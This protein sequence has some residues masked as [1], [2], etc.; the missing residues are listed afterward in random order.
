MV[1]GTHTDVGKTW[2]TAATAQA[3][4]SLGLAVA[5]RKP[6]ESFEASGGP[7]D[8]ELLAA[9]TAEDPALVCPRHRR[10][11][12]AMAPP[13][14]ADALGRPPFTIAELLGELRLPPRGIA[15]VETVGGPRSPIAADGDSV[16]LTGALQPDDVVLVGDAGLGAINALALSAAAL[17]PHPCHVFLN[18][19]DAGD[20]LHVANRCWL[21]ERLGIDALVD[22]ADLAALLSAGLSPGR[23]DDLDARVAVS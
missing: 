18:R 1:I 9:A 3:L 11:E 12:V 8:S 5:A 17:E 10:Y 15:L 4:G 2:V 16:A 20:E 6:V 21:R 7:T 19:F 14:A 22:V 23:P 13:M